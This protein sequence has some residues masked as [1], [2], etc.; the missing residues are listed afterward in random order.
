MPRSRPRKAF[1]ISASDV[2]SMIAPPTPW[3]AR[4]RFSISGELASPHDERRRREQRQPD[5]EDETAPVR[6]PS[7]PA[8]SRNAASV[9]EYALIT[10]WRS[11][12]LE[13]SERWIAAAP[14]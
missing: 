10:H 4:A 3:T 14:C 12:K 11:P 8:V 1:A 6:S 9:S 5:G 13:W 2:A 7:E